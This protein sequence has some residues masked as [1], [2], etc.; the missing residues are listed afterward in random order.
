MGQ[1]H[2]NDDDDSRHDLTRIEDLSEFLHEKDPDLEL[3][4]D[5]FQ[6]QQDPK[7]A[8]EETILTDVQSLDEP[9]LP[10]VPDEEA[11]E[12]NSEEQNLDFSSQDLSFSEDGP[13]N[14]ATEFSSLFWFMFNI[15]VFEMKLLFLVIG[16]IEC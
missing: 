10:P 5:D 14:E 13:E 11:E 15:L 3:K 9:E 12:I 7:A 16:G 4:F 8:P 1:G 2:N 6:G